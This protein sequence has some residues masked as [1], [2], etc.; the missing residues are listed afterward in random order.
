ME[1]MTKY[2]LWNAVPSLRRGQQFNAYSV[3]ER[4]SVRTRRTEKWLELQKNRD[5]KT[6]I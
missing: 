2:D 5:T 4:R 1:R 6:K 3:E